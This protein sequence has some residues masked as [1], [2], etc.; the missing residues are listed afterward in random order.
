MDIN[1]I[2]NYNFIF[3]YNFFLFNIKKERAANMKVL[4]PAERRVELLG[5][6]Y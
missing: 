1:T 6:E 5:N 4:L 2:L 3:L